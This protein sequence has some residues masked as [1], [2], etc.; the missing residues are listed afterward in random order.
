VLTEKQAKDLKRRH[1]VHLL[2]LPGVSGV[3]VQKNDAGG[4][5]VTVYLTDKTACIGLPSDLDGYPYKVEI[6]GPFHAQ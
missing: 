2:R 6:T 5:I 1:A 4:F 3:G